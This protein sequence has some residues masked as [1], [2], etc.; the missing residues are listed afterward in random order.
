MG[1]IVPR[2]T[3]FPVVAMISIQTNI[4]VVVGMD[5]TDNGRKPPNIYVFIR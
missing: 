2:K 5:K 1:S 3:N 4:G